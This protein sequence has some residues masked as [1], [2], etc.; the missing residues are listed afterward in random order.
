MSN[1]R[2]DKNVRGNV[3]IA[4]GREL[5]KIFEEIIVDKIDNVI[6]HFNNNPPRGEFVVMVFAND[7]ICT[8]CDI[9][10]KVRILKNKGYTP[11]DISVILSE[12][13]GFNKNKIYKISIGT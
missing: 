11:K 2:N 8:D 13:Y 4:I 6:E 1:Y 5:T 12:L 10:K 7:D 9:E 3:Q